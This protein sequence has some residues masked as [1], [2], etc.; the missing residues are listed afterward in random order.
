MHAS[1]FAQRSGY[2][3][4]LDLVQG[5][6]YKGA[7]YRLAFDRRFY[8]DRGVPANDQVTSL[9]TIGANTETGAVAF[10]TTQWSL[11]LEAQGESPAARE[12]LEKTLR[13]VLMAALWICEAQ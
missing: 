13:H 4:A 5:W 10:T 1:R 6:I 3:S 8:L 11:V 2:S 7:Q 12:A 9:S